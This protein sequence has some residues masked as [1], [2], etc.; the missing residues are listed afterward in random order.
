MVF[1]SF[2]VVALS[3]AKH[4][5]IFSQSVWLDFCC[6]EFHLDWS[7]N[8][9]YDVS[10]SKGLICGG[11]QSCIEVNGILHHLVDVCKF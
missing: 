4:E 6:K 7:F 10:E 5:N 1:S 2:K 11:L 3:I 8:G 9:A